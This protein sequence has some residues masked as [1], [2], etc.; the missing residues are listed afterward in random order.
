[1]YPLTC[2]GMVEKFWLGSISMFVFW[3][4][5]VTTLTLRPSFPLGPSKSDFVFPHIVTIV[6]KWNGFSIASSYLLRT[7]HNQIY[8]FP[9]F[10]RVFFLAFRA[11]ARILFLADLALRSLNL[12]RSVRPALLAFTA[13]RLLHVDCSHFSLTWKKN[14]FSLTFENKQKSNLV[15]LKFLADNPCWGIEWELDRDWCQLH[16]LDW[17][18]LSQDSRGW[19]INKDTVL[20]NYMTM[21]KNI[22]MKYLQNLSPYLIPAILPALGPSFSTAIRPISTNFLKGISSEKDKDL[23]QT[24]IKFLRL[25]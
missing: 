25:V 2:R 20:V 1:M 15:G 17:E 7:F 12:S 21:A 11:L 22:I 4:V 19:S 14:P 18:L 23:M 5:A 16:P 24:H 3:G 9:A 8:N 13:I 10:L 6:W